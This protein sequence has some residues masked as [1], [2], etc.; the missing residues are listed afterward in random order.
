MLNKQNSQGVDAVNIRNA[1]L[2]GALALV[3]SSAY[4]IT[5][6]FDTGIASIGT[7]GLAGGSSVSSTQYLGVRFQ[8]SGDYFATDIGG[9]FGGVYNNAN[10]FGAVIHLNSPTDFPVLQDLENDPNLVGV[11]TFSVPMYSEV[12]WG[13]LNVPISDGEW[14]ALVFGSGIFGAT[15][16]AS[17]PFEGVTE[18]TRTNDFWYSTTTGFLGE[19]TPPSTLGYFGIRGIPVVAENVPEPETYTLMLAALG[20]LGL[21]RHRRRK[22]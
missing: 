10:I 5:T 4:A 19:P 7:T 8:A 17:T 21:A 2:A 18:N 11:S 3:M 15:A 20:L 12:V 9:H 13:S 22:T 6:I 14:Y 1:V 16:S